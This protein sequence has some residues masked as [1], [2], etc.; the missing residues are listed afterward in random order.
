MA[1]YTK[2]TKDTATYT[3]KD[4]TDRGWFGTG[5]F[6]VPGWFKAYIYTKITKGLSIYTKVDK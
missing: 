3:K 2:I 1:T 6:S 4:K 5:W